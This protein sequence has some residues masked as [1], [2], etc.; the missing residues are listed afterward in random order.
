MVEKGYTNYLFKKKFALYPRIY[1]LFWEIEQYRKGGDPSGHSLAQRI[2]YVETG[3][4]I[5]KSNFW[6]GTGTGDVSDS[7]H[8]QYDI[9]KTQL[10]PKW[11]LRAHNQFLTFLLTFGIFGFLWFLFA[12]FTAPSIK[13]RYRYFIF[14]IFFLIG[15]LSMLNEDTLET[16]VGVSFFAFFY[17]FF[18]FSTPEINSFDNEKIR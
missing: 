16:H 6:F 10:Q 8:R 3:I 1:E 15:I 11:R 2:V 18:L 12:L 9:D 13:H 14:T 5:I 17:A 4:R 7:F